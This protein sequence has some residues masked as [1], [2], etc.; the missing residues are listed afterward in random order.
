MDTI[1]FRSVEPV[2]EFQWL[3]VIAFCM[4]LLVVYFYSQ[5]KKKVSQNGKNLYTN[6]KLSHNTQL[7]K[8]NIDGQEYLVFE[9]K[10][11]LVE[12]TSPHKVKD[13]SND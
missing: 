3:I 10:A 2:S 8:I 11:G 13:V 7:H 5:K 12:L 4:L 6:E 1:T 9:S